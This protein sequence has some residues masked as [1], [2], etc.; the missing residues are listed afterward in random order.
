MYISA[1]VVKSM[2]DLEKTVVVNISLDTRN[3]NLAGNTFSQQMYSVYVRPD[4]RWQ[5]RC[6]ICHAHCSVYDHQV[7]NYASWRAPNINGAPVYLLYRPARICCP[8]HGVKREFIPWADGNSRFTVSFNNE[9]AWLTG[10]LPKSAIA[11]LY[12][13]NWR[14]VENCFLAAQNRLAPDLSSRLNGIRRICVDE[15]SYSKG[16]KYITTIYDMDNYQA[17]WVHKDHGLEIFKTF[18]ETLTLDQRKGVKVV[19]GDGARWIDQCVVEYFPNA[20]RCI[21]SFHVVSWVNEAVD[22][23]RIL[24]GRQAGDELRKT[25]RLFLEQQRLAEEALAQANSELENARNAGED[26]TI[27]EKYTQ[28]VKNYKENEKVHGSK[29][30]KRRLLE[31]LPPEKQ[32]YLQQLKKNQKLLKNARYAVCKNPEN[33]T[34]SQ[35]DKLLMIATNSPELYAAYKVKER[36]RAIIHLRTV[37]VA[38]AEIDR[39]IKDARASK[40][41]PFVTLADK[42]AR[43]KQNLLNTIELQANSSQSESCNAKIQAMIRIAKGFRNLD[44]LIALIM[45][46]CSDL[47]IPLKNRPQLTQEQLSEMRRKAKEYRER[48]AAAKLEGNTEAA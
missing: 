30:D 19:A 41:E 27:L 2:L 23:V 39:W 3:V 9:I 5:H 43:H 6:P 45:L 28:T 8:E 15:T 25:E 16:H 10:Q 13:I 37:S 24:V 46:K 21:D 11:T 4:V 44:N 33:R 14:T 35:N 20:R 29:K 34:E 26:T 22:E 1:E 47:V 48:R 18:C 36:L 38:E 42:I 17:I 31:S 12:G 40:L 32:E 7:S